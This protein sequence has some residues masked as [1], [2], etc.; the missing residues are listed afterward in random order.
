MKAKHTELWDAAKAQLWEQFVAINANIKN[1]EKS[2][3]NNLIFHLIKL[4]KEEQTKPKE[5]KERN[6]KNY[7]RNKWNRE[8]ENI[9]SI[10]R[11]NKNYTKNKQKFMLWK[12][13]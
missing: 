13:Q 4:K 12:D 2:Q 6:N 9:K 7:S 1:Q 11:I 3:I 5:Q 10:Q 8:K